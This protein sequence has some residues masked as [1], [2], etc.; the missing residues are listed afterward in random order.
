M[1]M[2]Q[3]KKKIPD[4]TIMAT[5][6]LSYNPAWIPRRWCTHL[7]RSWAA[8]GLGWWQEAGSH[9]H[10]RWQK[11]WKRSWILWQCEGRHCHSY[12]WRPSE[13]HRA[14]DHQHY[15]QKQQGD[16]GYQCSDKNVMKIHAI[17]IESKRRIKSYF[18]KWLFNLVS[19]W[20]RVYP[21]YKA[22]TGMRK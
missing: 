6:G 3:E 22:T 17:Y 16:Q 2:T 18:G 5:H 19:W 4:D 21:T 8:P 1:G 15:H 14:Q 11:A 12:R 13:L 7:S 9:H 10:T 20:N